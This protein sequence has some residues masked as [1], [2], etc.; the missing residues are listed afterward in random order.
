MSSDRVWFVAERFERLKDVLLAESYAPDPGPRE[1]NEWQEIHKEDPPTG[2][3]RLKGV[4]LRDL[5]DEFDDEITFS[6]RELWSPD[7]VEEAQDERG[8]YLV[9]YSYHAQCHGTDQ[10]WDFDPDGHP[11][12]PYHHHPP[13]ENSRRVS[14]GPVAPGDALAMFRQ[15]MSDSGFSV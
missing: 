8:F 7:Y 10:R 12:M 2:L 4:R 14:F 11:E 6:I 9:Q 3:V 15:W 13:G 1:P 5:D